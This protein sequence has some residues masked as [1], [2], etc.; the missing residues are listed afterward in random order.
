MFRA[1]YRHRVSSLDGSP[2]SSDLN[3]PSTQ[4]RK[5]A[6]PKSGLELSSNEAIGYAAAEAPTNRP[7]LRRYAAT[8][9][10]KAEPQRAYVAGSGT[11]VNEMPFRTVPFSANWTV[12][13]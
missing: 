11:G 5:K 6:A 2:L 10:S 13:R 1:G 9:S 8:P 12:F 3:P 4:G 7:R